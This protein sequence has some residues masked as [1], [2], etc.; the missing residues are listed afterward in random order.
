MFEEIGRTYTHWPMYK[1]H[2]YAQTLTHTHTHAHTHSCTHALTHKH[3][4]IRTLAPHRPN[5]IYMHGLII[6]NVP[7]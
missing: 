5:Y 7:L 1:Q 6:N 2:I 3:T 4:H